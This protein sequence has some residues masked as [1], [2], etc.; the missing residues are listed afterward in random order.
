[1]SLRGAQ[2]ISSLVIASPAGAKQSHKK[3]M[4]LPRRYA[5]R[6][7]IQSS[8]FEAKPKTYSDAIFFNSSFK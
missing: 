1:M 8:N 2:K 5:P 3:R 6:N 4:R 7:D